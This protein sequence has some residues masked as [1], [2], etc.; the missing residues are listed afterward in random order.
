MLLATSVRDSSSAR[1]SLMLFGTPCGLA[2]SLVVSRCK[3]KCHLVKII[4]KIARSHLPNLQ[5]V[6]P[7]TNTES[8]NLCGILIP[9]PDVCNLESLLTRRSLK[10][11]RGVFANEMEREVGFLASNLAALTG[12]CFTE[13]KVN[14]FMNRTPFYQNRVRWKSSWCHCLLN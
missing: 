12:S 9:W 14:I 4:L 2:A 1:A 13:E 10:V 11:A 6:I 3:I 5:W 7:G 8:N